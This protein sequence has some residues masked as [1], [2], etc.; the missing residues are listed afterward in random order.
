MERP[1]DQI[2]NALKEAM[3]NKDGQRRDVLRLLTSAFKQQEIDTQKEV[4]DEQALDIL[5]KEAKK[6]R[7]SIA[8]LTAAHRAEQLAAEQ[9]ELA[10][11][12]EFLPRQLT[13]AEIRAIV[14]EAIASTGAVGGK[15]MGKVMTVI[16][17]RTK[18]L[19]DGK[20]VSQIVKELLGN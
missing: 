7:E 20:L 1:K 18:G 2:N 16:Q 12:E 15:E 4:T 17:P 11:I 3:K 10:L 5:Q 13:E 19:A 8:E 14:T 9:Y 6:R